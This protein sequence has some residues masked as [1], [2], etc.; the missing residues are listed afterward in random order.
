MA[1]R[2]FYRLYGLISSFLKPGRTCKSRQWTGRLADG[3][4]THERLF[5]FLLTALQ[6]K[7]QVTEECSFQRCV[8]IYDDLDTHHLKGTGVFCLLIIWVIYFLLRQSD[9]KRQSVWCHLLECHANHA[10]VY[11]SVWS[12]IQFKASSPCLCYTFV[13][14]FK[15]YN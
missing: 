3:S 6:K 13:K 11:V 1:L 10:C 2:C 8:V 5:R 12:S 7:F 9:R 15:R 14:V 4:S